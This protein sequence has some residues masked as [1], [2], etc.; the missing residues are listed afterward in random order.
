MT[1]IR[2]VVAEKPTRS[3]APTLRFLI[4]SISVHSFSK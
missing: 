2:I 1:T 3:F 4:Q